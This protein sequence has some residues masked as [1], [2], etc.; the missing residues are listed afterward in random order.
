LIFFAVFLG[1]FALVIKAV[2]EPVAYRYFPPSPTASSTPT[3]TLTPTITPTLKDTLT[4][5]SR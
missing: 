4:R 5:P 2:G 1:I 3:I